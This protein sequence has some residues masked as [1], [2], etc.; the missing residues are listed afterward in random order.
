MKV[1]QN[2]TFDKERAFYGSKELY[3]KNCKFDGPADGESA[4]KE[5]R[6]IE[7]DHSFMNLRY[8]FRHD[9]GVAIRNCELTQLCRAALWYSEDVVIEDSKLHG[10]VK[11]L[12]LKTDLAFERSD[13]EA[14]ITTPVISIKNPLSG[15]ISVPEIGEIIRDIDHANG[16]VQVQKPKKR[17]TCACA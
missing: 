17:H 3:V 8:P 10:I 4:F 13:V 7:V 14:V 9:R 5:C 1:I 11:M 12:H 2:Q 15:Y 6:E 16:I